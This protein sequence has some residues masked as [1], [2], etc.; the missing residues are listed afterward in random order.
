MHISMKVLS[1]ILAHIATCSAK[2]AD[3]K[4]PTIEESAIYRTTVAAAKS[5]EVFEGLPHELLPN[6]KAVYN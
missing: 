2:A 4:S 5:I 1:F 3:E 6:T